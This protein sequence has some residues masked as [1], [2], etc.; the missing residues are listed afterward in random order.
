MEASRS[1]SGVAATTLSWGGGT[2]QY[3]LCINVCFSF[4]QY[5]TFDDFLMVYFVPMHV[6]AFASMILLMIF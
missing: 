5:D 4:C 3:N 6:I 1:P 2:S